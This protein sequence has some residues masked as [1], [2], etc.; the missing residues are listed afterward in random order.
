MK[1]IIIINVKSRINP[2]DALNE[3]IIIRNET[4]TSVILKKF[5]LE[6]YGLLYK[7]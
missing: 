6:T 3:K 1:N 7:L 4:I 5:E 2:Y